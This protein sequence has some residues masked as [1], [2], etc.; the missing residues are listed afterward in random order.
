MAKLHVLA[1]QMVYAVC[2][3]FLSPWIACDQ[4]TSMRKSKMDADIGL[5][6]H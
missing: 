3:Q 6:T 4:H 2:Q 5:N 1:S